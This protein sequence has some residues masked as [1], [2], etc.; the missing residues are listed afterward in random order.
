MDGV[1]SECW[2]TIPTNKTIKS[3]RSDLVVHRKTHIRVHILE[4]AC[5]WTSLIAETER[6][7]RGKYESLAADYVK[8]LL[9]GWRV[10]IH[11]W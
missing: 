10:F 9:G 5:T 2:R 1:E 4:I 6:E 3:N 8:Q 7:K 11:H